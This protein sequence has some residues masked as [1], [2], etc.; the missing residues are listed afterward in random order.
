MKQI[1]Y[2]RYD[3]LKTILITLMILFALDYYVLGLAFVEG[4]S[5]HPTINPYNRL[6]YVKLP[7][8]KNNPKRGDIVIFQPPKELERDELFVKRVIAIEEDIYCIKNGILTINDIEI[9]E[10]YICEEIYRNKDYPHTD[11][12]VPADKVFVMGDNRNNSNDS[13][14]FCCIYTQQIKG[15]VIMRIWPLDEIKTFANP[16]L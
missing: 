7:Y 9:E 1:S 8:F 13:R 16:F 2:K 6:I 14:R 15:K 12:I 5:M 11:G 3:L 10:E 4:E